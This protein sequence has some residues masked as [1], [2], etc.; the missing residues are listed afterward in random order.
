MYFKKLIQSEARK[1]KKRRLDALQDFLK[2]HGKSFV[3]QQRTKKKLDDKIK[4]RMLKLAT[5][6]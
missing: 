2:K 6:K 1:S 4:R 3:N 5:F